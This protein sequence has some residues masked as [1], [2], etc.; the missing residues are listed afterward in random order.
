MYEGPKFRNDHFFVSTKP[1]LKVPSGF[2]GPGG[3]PRTRA[4][5]HA[6]G[7]TFRP[8]SVAGARVGRSD[9]RSG[10]RG[11]ARRPCGRHLAGASRSPFLASAA[12]STRLICRC[13]WRARLPASA[14]SSRP[15]PSGLFRAMAGSWAAMS[16]SSGRGHRGSSV[17]VR[18]MIGGRSRHAWGWEAS[19]ME[20]LPMANRER[21]AEVRSWGRS[22]SGLGELGVVGTSATPAPNTADPMYT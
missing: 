1:V 21:G 4:P 22:R 8:G 11:F 3:D 19:S 14:S 20:A 17:F 18:P 15:A 6:G 2:G 7:T 9:P 13:C 12:L 5:R 16:D 10:S